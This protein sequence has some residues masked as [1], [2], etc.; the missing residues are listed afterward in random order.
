MKEIEKV[1]YEVKIF[2]EK[3]I[4][5]KSNNQELERLFYGTQVFYSPVKKS[6]LLILGFNPGPGYYNKEKKLVEKFNPETKHEYI[7]A[8]YPLANQTRGIFESINKLIDLERSVKSNIYFTATK[9]VNEFKQ[10]TN[11]LKKINLVNDFWHYSKQWQNKIIENVAPNLILCEGFNVYKDLDYH[12]NIQ[13]IEET[14]TIRVGKIS[15][16][17]KDIIV[18]SYKRLYSNIQNPILVAEKLQE[19]LG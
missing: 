1:S 4:K 3:L 6:N 19:Y 2:H 10:L 14:A 16:K 18:I 17:E 15:L 13:L 7:T 5:L 12:F 8:D 11:E 9:G